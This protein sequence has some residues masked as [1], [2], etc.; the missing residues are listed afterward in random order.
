MGG[1]D[2]AGRG[3]AIDRRVF[4]PERIVL[5]GS[6]VT[7]RM[8]PNDVDC[9]LLTGQGFPKDAAAVAELRA[10]LPF[11]DIALVRRGR[12]DRLVNVFFATD[13]FEVPKGMVEVMT[14]T[15]TAR[16]RTAPVGTVSRRAA[17]V[18]RVTR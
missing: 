1:P 2:A 4:G 16:A 17:M 7:D 5:N 14:K 6:F 8:E 10:G 13:L 11:L 9:V 12:F 15:L 3:A 18:P